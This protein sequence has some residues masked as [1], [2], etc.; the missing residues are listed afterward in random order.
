MWCWDSAATGEAGSS[1]VAAQK[2]FK[3]ILQVYL[4]TFFA[5]E[6]SLRYLSTVWKMEKI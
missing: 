2:P 1:M 5:E 3:D 6:V 4:K